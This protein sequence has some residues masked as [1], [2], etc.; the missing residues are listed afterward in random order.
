MASQFIAQ[1]N[2]GLDCVLLNSKE[3]ECKTHLITIIIKLSLSL[4]CLQYIQIVGMESM[5]STM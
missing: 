1:E 2:N 4:S 3:L 5:R